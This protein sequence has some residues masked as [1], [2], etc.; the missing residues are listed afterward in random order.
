MSTRRAA[1][2]TSHPT[3]AN[4][5]AMARPN[6]LDAPVTR[7]TFLSRSNKAFPDRNDI[8]L[9]YMTHSIKTQQKHTTTLSLQDA[10]ELFQSRGAFH[11]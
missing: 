7:A 2:M 6:P 3:D 9:Q 1:S 8:F 11:D 4:A 10:L 5:V